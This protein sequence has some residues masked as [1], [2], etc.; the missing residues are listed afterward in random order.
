MSPA[1]VTGHEPDR[2][3]SHTCTD[4]IPKSPQL[5]RLPKSY[6]TSSEAYTHAVWGSYHGSRSEVCHAKLNSSEGLHEQVWGLNTYKGASGVVGF[7]SLEADMLEVLRSPG[8]E[9][10]IP[11]RVLKLRGLGFV[12]QDLASFPFALTLCI[13]QPSRY[14]GLDPRYVMKGERHDSVR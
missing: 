6:R 12:F 8:R 3:Y 7:S 11:T 13:Y 5:N 10:G 4:S 9:A 1:Q 2:R 14:V